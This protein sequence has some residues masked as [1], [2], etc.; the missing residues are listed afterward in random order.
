MMFT[1]MVMD[2]ITYLLCLYLA[3]YFGE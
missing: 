3:R 2:S 1:F